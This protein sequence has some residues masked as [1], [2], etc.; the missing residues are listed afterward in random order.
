MNN[1]KRAGSIYIA[2]Q[3]VVETA[4]SSSGPDNHRGG[5]KRGNEGTAKQPSRA[6]PHT[7]KPL[8]IVNFLATVACSILLLLLHKF[9]VI[10][11][12]NNEFCVKV[13]EKLMVG[14]PEGRDHAGDPCLD[15]KIILEWIFGK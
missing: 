10:R 5:R 12:L 2:R 3:L 15:G 8:Y 14:K 13:S 9:L 7:S 6:I 4:Q 1:A 11:R